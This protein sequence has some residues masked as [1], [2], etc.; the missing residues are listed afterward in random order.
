MTL[1][2]SACDFDSTNMTRAHHLQNP[3]S[4]Y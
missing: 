4:W 2:W 1:T 3:T